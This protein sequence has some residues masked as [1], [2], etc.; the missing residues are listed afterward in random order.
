M[1]N[2]IVLTGTPGVGKTT[3]A[4]ALAKEDGYDLIELNALAV[5]I[6]AI[7]G[8]DPDRGA[9]IIDDRKLRRELTRV[10]SVEGRKFLVEGHY[11]DIVPPK[12]VQAAIVI[13]LN[14][15]LLKARLIERGYPMEKVKENLEAEVLDACLL[16]AVA[17]YGKGVVS[18]VDA[19]GL[20][21][22]ELVSKV[23]EGIAGR[24]LPPG[25]INWVEALQREGS[26]LEYL[27]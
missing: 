22:Q 18:E 23:R 7:S 27:G 10:L 4:R 14:P 3:V 9:A 13:R 5:E 12:F 20:G 6:G 17:A 16:D 25:S 15:K 11:A 1:K 21:L 26:L 8:N 19:S 24:G 2:T